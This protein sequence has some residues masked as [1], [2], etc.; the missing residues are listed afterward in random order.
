MSIDSAGSWSIVLAGG[1]GERARAFIERWLGY[2]KPK[3]YCAFTGTRS[4][5]QHTVDRADVLGSPERRIVV[6]APEHQGYLLEQLR[7]RE[8]GRVVLQPKNRGTAPGVFLALTYVLARDPDATVMIYPSDHFVYPESTFLNVVRTAMWNARRHPVGPVLLGVQPSTTELDY[9]W[10]V[11]SPVESNGDA[12][13]VEAFLEKPPRRLA[14]EALRKGALWNTMIVAS[15]VQALWSLGWRSLPEIMPAFTRL[16]DTLRAGRED[17]PL[18]EIYLDLPSRD[19]S[20][21]L[22]QRASDRSRVLEMTGVWWSDWGRP[23][24][25]LETLRALERPAAFPEALVLELE[26]AGSLG[27][28]PVKTNEPALSGREP[29]GW[30]VPS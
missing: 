22:L 8:G 1:E 3:Q 19:F 30:L 16:L 7:G 12:R 15:K 27:G 28:A 23:E 25:I 5:F 2:H 13:R 11:P 14:E 18:E 24:R 9:G 10:I 4:L 21:G 26:E 29:V 6:A 20:S 17:T